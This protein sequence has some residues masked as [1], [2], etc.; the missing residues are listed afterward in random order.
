M[1]RFWIIEYLWKKYYTHNLENWEFSYQ[2]ALQK[3]WK[4]IERYFESWEKQHKYLDLR[5]S[6]DQVS[7]LVET[8]D[9]F[10]K[11]NKEELFI[12]WH[13]LLF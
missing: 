10:D 1:E 7:V 6:D 5:F 11:R 13:L 12:Y 8:K 9:N 3:I 4:D 2:K